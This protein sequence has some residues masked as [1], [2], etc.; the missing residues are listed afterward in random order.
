MIYSINPKFPFFTIPE[1]N[2][3]FLKYVIFL[4]DFEKMKKLETSKIK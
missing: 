4:M 3:E 2:L 1:N